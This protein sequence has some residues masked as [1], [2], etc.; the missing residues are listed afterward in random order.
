MDFIRESQFQAVY[1]SNVNTDTNRP[2]IKS[3]VCPSTVFSGPLHN[4]EQYRQVCG[5]GSRVC[6]A[7]AGP[8]LV[9]LLQLDLQMWLWQMQTLLHSERLVAVAVTLHFIVTHQPCSRSTSFRLCS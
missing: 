6:T 3:N 1:F 7:L 4:S 5:F 8:E 2:F 9:I